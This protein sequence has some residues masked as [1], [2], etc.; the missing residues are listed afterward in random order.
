MLITG[1]VILFVHS[2]NYF[3]LEGEGKTE[4]PD[5]WLEVARNG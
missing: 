4:T 3:L 5:K 1:W 2:A